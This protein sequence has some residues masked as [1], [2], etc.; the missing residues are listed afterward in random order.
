VIIDL[1]LH[2][3]EDLFLPQS[4]LY[5]H[6]PSSVR[7]LKRR[8]GFRLIDLSE[9]LLVL[10]YR[11][12]VSFLDHQDRIEEDFCFFLAEDRFRRSLLLL[13]VGELVW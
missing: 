10:L 12:A 5:S 6:F 9:E 4:N 8:K 2:S 1:G 7:S 3:L 13:L 11:R